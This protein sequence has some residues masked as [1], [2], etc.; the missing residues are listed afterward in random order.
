MYCF[1]K[2]INKTA[3]IRI[4]KILFS[5]REF[6]FEPEYKQNKVS[7]VLFINYCTS[8]QTVLVYEKDN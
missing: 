2:S 4:F 3:V 7:V 8:Y 6:D 1:I 5:C